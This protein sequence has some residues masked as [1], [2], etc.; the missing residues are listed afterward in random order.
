MLVKLESASDRIYVVKVATKH[1]T[2]K[3]MST[4]IMANR[5]MSKQEVSAPCPF[6]PVHL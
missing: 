5:I 4:E 1:D 2:S 6:L 3:A